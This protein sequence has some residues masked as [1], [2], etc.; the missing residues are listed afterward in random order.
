VEK[1]TGIGGFFFRAADPTALAHWYRDHLGVALVPSSYDE[2]PWQQEAGP[3]AFAPFPAATTYFGDAKQTWMINFRVLNLDAM[4]AQLRAA[5][6]AVEI[7][8]EIYPN[9]RF[10]RIADPE[11]NPIQLWEPKE[12][13]T[14]AN[15][16]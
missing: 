13:D 11:G 5:G 7:D 2:P 14:L 15:D 1:V 9:G 8:P 10:A 3:T 4:V 16:A 12:R 6:I